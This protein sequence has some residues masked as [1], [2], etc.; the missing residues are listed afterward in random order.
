MLALNLEPTS[1]EMVWR[2][3]TWGGEALIRFFCHRKESVT[4]L[5]FCLEISLSRN[6]ETNMRQLRRMQETGQAGRQEGRKAGRE[7]SLASC[8][9]FEEKVYKKTENHEEDNK[10]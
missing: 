2:Q 5:T 8:V 3:Y 1:D 6:A 7:L 9:P 10:L 4:T